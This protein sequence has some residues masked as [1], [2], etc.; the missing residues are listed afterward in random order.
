MAHNVRVATSP[1]NCR[2]IDPASRGAIDAFE[3]AVCRRIKGAERVLNEAECRYCPAW[4]PP[5]SGL[6]PL[7]EGRTLPLPH[8][9][10]KMRR[11]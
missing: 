10:G 3:Y 1:L 8:A 4:T 6:L 5:D 9:S 2:W 7:R 11:A